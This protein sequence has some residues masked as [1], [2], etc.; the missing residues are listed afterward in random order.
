M[1]PPERVP[2]EC[3]LYGYP[4]KASEWKVISRY[5]RIVSPSIICED[6]PREDPNLYLSSNSPMGFNRSSIVVHKN[7][8]K[9]A[10]AK[11]RIYNGGNHWIKITFDSW[12]AAE[13]AC[14]YSPVEIDGCLV[15]CE[16]WAGKGPLTDAP[17]P[18]SADPAA[19]QL[20][21]AQRARTIGTAAGK[22]SAVAGFEQAIG[23]T[24]PR[25]HTMPDAQYRQ[26]ANGTRDD[27]D[28]VSSTTASSATATSPNPQPT[29]SASTGLEVQQQSSSIRS[30]SVPNLP[31]QATTNPPS[32]QFMSH[33][34]QIRRVN[35]RP[36]A[37]ALPPQQSLVE[38]VLRSIPVVSWVLGPTGAP[39]KKDEKEKG[40]AGLI[41]EGPVVKEDGSWD[42]S[43]N[44]WYWG[45]WW[46]VDKL[47]GS[48]FCGMKED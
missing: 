45:F 6:Y 29:H 26:P 2:T 13:R 1:L 35:L 5:E 15:H 22:A 39:V 42:E 7:L 8:S 33:A 31:S 4:S 3:L 46:R 25:N 19:G 21:S 27:L 30:R 12:E 38:R 40:G 36:I 37:E 16:M 20:I 9:E 28:V 24:L 10:L 17:I 14:F 47:F 44:G 23:G 32:S 41:G 48:D 18:K 11:S 43:A 34:P